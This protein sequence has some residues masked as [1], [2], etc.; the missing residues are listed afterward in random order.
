MTNIKW[1]RGS[2]LN[3]S[4]HDFQIA[5]GPKGPPS[6][7]NCQSFGRV[8]R[9]KTIRSALIFPPKVTKKSDLAN[10]HQTLDFVRKIDK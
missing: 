9:P 5:V 3:N 8:W 10:E 6:V 1:G 4:K 2:G 7:P